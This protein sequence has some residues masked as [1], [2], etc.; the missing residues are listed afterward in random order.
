VRRGEA[1][2]REPFD[3]DAYWDSV[4][5][6]SLVDLPASD[7]DQRVGMSP[8]TEVPMGVVEYRGGTWRILRANP[9]Y[10]DFLDKT[11]MLPK[12]YS[13]LRANP[14]CARPD[15]EFFVA[16]GR[17]RETGLWERIMGHMEYGS[18][19]QFFVRHVTSTSGAEAYMVAGSPTM[20]GSALGAFGDVPVAYAVFRVLLDETREHVEDIEYVY[21]NV[22]YCRW[23]GYEQ[24]DLPGRSFLEVAHHASRRWFPACYDAAVLRKHVHGFMYSPESQ[25][26]LSYNAAPTLIE[27]CCVFAFTFADD[28]RRER[29]EMMVGLDTSDLIISIADALGG[30]T[31]YE[32]AMNSL[33]ETM[34][35]I[36]HPERLYVYERG[37]TT[38]RNTFEW[39]AEGVESQIATLQDI[40]NEEL[41][42]WDRLLEEDSV[43]TIDDVSKIALLDECLH[44]K[45]VR[46]GITR[47]LAVPFYNEG[48]L[49]GYLGADNYRFEEG[50]DTRR[51][52]GT[53]ASFVGARV[54]NHRLLEEMQR[55]GTYDALTGLLNRRGIDLAVAEHHKRRPDEPYTLALMDVDDFKTVNDLHGHDVGDEALRELARRVGD[56]FG[57]DAIV[58]RNGGDEFLVMLCGDDSLRADAL[59]REFVDQEFSCE[60]H[61]R[62][63]RLSMSVGYASCPD[64]TCG[65]ME[66]Y[67]LADAALYAVKLGGKGGCARYAP[68]METQFRSQLGFTPHDIARNIPGGILV[69]RQGDDEIL[70]ANDEIIELFECDGLE[71]FL[72]YT[73]GT[74]GGVVHPDDRDRVRKEL[75][76]QVEMV[77]KGAKDF[78]DFRVL[79]KRGNVRHVADNG[80]RVLVEGVGVLFYELIVNRDERGVR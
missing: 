55:L 46:Q 47:M 17:S 4:S 71:D 69:H 41:A 7:D 43:I 18:G 78:V 35:T 13:T 39:C 52:L 77:D 25:H 59:F 1:L 49:L 73:G 48:E 64:Q 57:H 19:Y 32:V 63:Y 2:P 14:V 65:L 22:H 11:G 20:L 3:E 67:T 28:E 27:G 8:M 37:A 50:L 61:G 80:K 66:L 68:S 79:T 54:T 24:G 72:S 38:T 6:L 21:A 40:D 30:E 56:A 23:G 51:L 33:L 29:E 60:L 58:G 75:T 15:E 34:S 10:A 74:F 26:W 31:S 44:R 70:F 36:I 42:V 12:P 45:L 53:V 5:L 76:E 62:T 16:A 9:A